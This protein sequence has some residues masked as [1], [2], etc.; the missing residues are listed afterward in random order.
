[1]PRPIAATV[2]MG[3]LRHNLARMRACAGD[4]TLWAVV[5]ANAYGH[6]AVRVAKVLEN[7]NAAVLVQEKREHDDEREVRQAIEELDEVRQP[8]VLTTLAE[9]S[10]FGE[11]LDDE[12][13]FGI[14][15]K[16]VFWYKIRQGLRPCW[17]WWPACGSA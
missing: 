4:R 8:E 1:M 15:H 3:S 10:E 7:M 6:G 17:H 2:H 12:V 5:K 9:Y 14:T 11:V 13:L 16:S